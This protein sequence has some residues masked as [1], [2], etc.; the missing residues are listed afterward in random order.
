M[1]SKITSKKTLTK[2]S[3]EYLKTRLENRSY[4]IT[5]KNFPI[6][7]TA[8]KT[9]VDNK[10]IM[11]MAPTD[12][13]KNELYKAHSGVIHESGHIKFSS[14]RFEDIHKTIY[15]NKLERNKGHDAL[16]I[17]EDYRVN[18]LIQTTHPGAGKLM[19][20]VH[21][22]IVSKHTYK[23]AYAAL[24][25]VLCGHKIKMEL[26]K[27]EQEK[28]NKAVKIIKPVKYSLSL[29]A[30]LKVLPDVYKIF[31]KENDKEKTP[32]ER[33]QEAKQINEKKETEMH[34]EEKH[35]NEK[36][37]KRTVQKNIKEAVKKLEE[38]EKE[39]GETEA[40]PGGSGKVNDTEITELSK[41]L[42]K[43]Q[44][45]TKEKDE[46]ETAKLI[47][48]TENIE[49]KIP[50]TTLEEIDSD[51]NNYNYYKN[52]NNTATRQLIREMQKL[53][54]YSRRKN[55]GYRNGKIN[56][57]KAYK[58]LTSNDVKIFS[59]K[60]DKEIG[61][62]AVLLLV[63]CSGS[64]SSDKRYSYAK[65][66]SIILHEVLRNLKIK[67]MIVGYTA[68]Y[69]KF[70]ETT[71]IIYKKWNESNVAYNLSKIRPYA[72]NRDGETIRLG[73]AYFE[74]V[75]A[76]KKI[77]IVISDGQPSARDYRVAEGIEDTV[78]AQKEMTK[79]GIKLINIGIGRDFH[80]P[81]SYINKVKVDNVSLLPNT[82][83]KVL[84]KELK[85]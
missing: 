5:H 66:C 51:I 13:S 52:K 80:L 43:I 18:M 74:N 15:D 45:R 23:T 56:S 71:H 33:E 6:E 21:Q 75:K 47:E 14:L 11:I 9:A 28:L 7:F 19:F 77:A 61:N 30:S 63:D 55:N 41:Q 42:T 53:F 24:L 60:T 68:D 26:S 70:K 17:I 65:E 22:D 39:T 81:T 76:Q 12:F 50:I 44:N 46:K 85:N 16:N 82:L 62:T 34:P 40:I 35:L 67:H 2:E 57:K 58:I 37:G 25:P 10:K 1:L 32:E 48:S 59:K 84:R 20:K 79:K 4:S 29:D 69:N 49:T 64:M 73:T 3:I 36:K 8:D 83:L 54:I 31:F 78:K 27:K 38:K 72:N